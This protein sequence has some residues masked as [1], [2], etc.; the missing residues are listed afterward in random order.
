MKL[1]HLLQAYEFDEIMPVINDMFPGTSKFREQL[2]QAYD[3]LIAMKP[4]PSNKVIRY[5]VLSG[6]KPNHSFVGAEDSCFNAIWE[7]CLGKEVTKENGVDLSN[8][9]LVANCLVNL[10]LQAK[11]PKAFETAHRQLMK[12]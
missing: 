8:A 12:G 5:K 3:M 6:D 11:Y 4:V 1:N 2:K 7:V 10:C 9:E